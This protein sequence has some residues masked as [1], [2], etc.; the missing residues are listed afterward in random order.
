[1]P[2]PSQHD[3]GEPNHTLVPC[4]M[5]PKPLSEKEPIYGLFRPNPPNTR[6]NHCSLTFITTTK[7]L[8]IYIEYVTSL[9]VM[10]YNFANDLHD[11]NSYQK[12]SSC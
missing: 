7:D 6:V 4:W 12:H 2:P 9:D 8:S 3:L 5:M 11:N 1:M 10:Y